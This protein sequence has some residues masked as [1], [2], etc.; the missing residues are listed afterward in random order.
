MIVLINNFLAFHKVKW[1]QYS[2]EVGKCTN[3]WCQTFSGFN[4]I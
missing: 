1:L 4:T 3:C 2:G